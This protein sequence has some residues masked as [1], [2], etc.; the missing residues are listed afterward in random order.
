MKVSGRWMCRW[1]V[2]LALVLLFTSR[3]ALAE[4]IAVSVL[5]GDAKGALRA[6]VTA[7]L[8]KARQ[9]Q[10]LPPTAWAKAAQKQGLPGELS[11]QPQAVALLA[12]LLKVDAVLIG[13]VAGDFNARLL[14]KEGEELWSGSFPLKRGLLPPQEAARFA[15]AVSTAVKH[16][17]PQTPPP[18]PPV[19]AAPPPPATPP[20]A[21]SAPVTPSAQP[22]ATPPA[23]AAQA[24]A[25][26]QPAPR[27][28]SATPPQS[29]AP[30]A[31]VRTPLSDA[32]KMAEAG[33]HEPSRP[34]VAEA[35]V[36]NEEVDDESHTYTGPARGSGGGFPRGA[37]TEATPKAPGTVETGPQR[38]RVLLGAVATWRQYC[39]RP[40]V[41]SCAQYDALPAD[42][43]TGDTADF[44]ARAPYVGLAA[45]AEVFP[46]SHLSS[47]VRGLGLVLAYQRSF[48]QT[49]VAVSTTTGSTPT[50]DVYATDTAY[51]AML[52]YRYF[53]GLGSPSAPLW[54]HVGL[55]LGV[56]GRE[57]GVDETVDA[58][59]PVAHRIFPAVG[60]DVSVPLMRVLRIEGSGSFFFRP[61]PGQALLGLGSGAQVAEVRDYGSAVSSIGGAAELGV[62]GEFW[63]PLGYSARVRWEHYSDG[64]T[65]AGARRGWTAGGVAE[66]TYVTALAGLTLGW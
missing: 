49:S 57:F 59:L 22:S 38:V 23:S 55:R 15:L 24:S 56:A 66:D 33:T 45:Q 12:P 36:A 51:G 13:A 39:A 3:A 42:Q 29:P 44:T 50:R 58:P 54:G 7:A 18:Q 21:A 28:P 47:R 9:V 25:P 11:M 48:A 26:A 40:G 64:F 43:R 35:S 14:D 17:A 2:G 19:A 8:R 61:V 10:V 27:S 60:L 53:F 16:P 30:T 41:K 32:P 65:G 37:S 34:L 63:G 62:A 4:R 52:A 20:P 1:G 46:L 31:T 6:Q 5:T